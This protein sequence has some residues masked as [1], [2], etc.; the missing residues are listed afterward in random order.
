MSD[1]KLGYVVMTLLG[2]FVVIVGGLF[3]R[4][5]W[6]PADVRYVVFEEI[7]NLRIDDP[8]SILGVEVGKISDVRRLGDQVLVEVKTH[9]K[10]RIHENYRIRTIDKG[11]MGDRVIALDCGD[12]R[13]PLLEPSD[14]LRGSFV[15]GLSEA[16]G[17][18]WRLKRVVHHYRGL[19]ASFA[20]G[21]NEDAP[22]RRKVWNMLRMLDTLSGNV[23]AMMISLDASLSTTLDT[24]ERFSRQVETF[25]DTMAST[26]PDLLLRLQDDFVPRCD[27]LLTQL[28]SLAGQLSESVEQADD[29]ESIVWSGQVAR[30]SEL[31]KSVRAA[32]R[33][34]ESDGIPLQIKIL[35]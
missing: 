31:L 23:T 12:K 18:A 30:L 26:V 11:L 13:K 27:S 29:P 7:G 9:R 17:S 24:L 22:I 6:F 33:S 20:R 8:V 2:L 19:S 35:H 15:P 5:A 1:R 32:L 3:V 21:D 28:D 14:T 10:L 4:V 25:S 34:L 16:I